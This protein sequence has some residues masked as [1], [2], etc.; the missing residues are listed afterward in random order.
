MKTIRF[1]HST[2]V[3]R[4]ILVVVAMLINVAWVQAGTRVLYSFEG[5]ESG[6]YP[7]TELVLDP[8]GN[9]YGTTVEG[10][11]FGGGTVFQL[12]RSQTGWVHRV[13]YSFSGQAD[14]GQPYGG[15]TLDSQGNLYGSAV[16]GGTG[17]TCVEDGCGVIYKLTRSGGNWSYRVIYNFTGG[18]D[19]YGPGTGL[20]LDEQGN[21]YGMTPT[22]GAFGLGVI[23]QLGPRPNGDWRF[24]VIHA[25]TGDSDGG[26]GSAGRLLLDDIGNL[27]GVATVGGE[28]EK[29]VAFKLTRT[30]DQQWDFTTLYAFKG[31]PDAGFPYGGLISDQRGNLYGTTYYDGAYNLGSVY[32]LSF[33]NRSWHE[34]VL[35][36]FQGGADGANP[37]SN[38]VFDA[39]NNLYA[40]TSEG[41]APGCGCGT[42][43]QLAPRGDG[44][45]VERVVH[46][47]QGTPD[48]AYPYSGMASDP[49]GHFYGATV[50]GGADDDGSIYAF[51]P[52][53]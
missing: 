40:T 29:G 8:A 50:H 20:T 17:G 22:G 30:P 3:A 1:S 13:L 41:G 45:W 9:L 2:I 28:H 23:F 5:D 7:S 21:L 35:Y 26:T 25:F 52:K 33:S 46:R 14:G 19:G 37:I 42:I 38:L 10:G 47:F 6:E 36:S 51:R 53:P 12:R 31:Q 32:K 4:T 15:V 34:R 44:K 11:D 18:D 49:A 48:G 24:R 27:Y 16:I 39:A 43:F